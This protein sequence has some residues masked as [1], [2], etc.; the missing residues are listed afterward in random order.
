[1]LPIPS[2]EQQLICD[3]L[4]SGKNV[5]VNAVAGAGK[6]TT[7][8]L[9]M[10]TDSER[11][12]LLLTYNMELKNTTRDATLE[13]EIFNLEVHS[14]NSFGVKYISD[15]CKTDSGFLTDYEVKSLPQYEKI[16]IDEIQDCTHMYYE[17]IIKILDTQHD[18]QLCVLG[19]YKQTIFAFKGA[20]SRYLTLADKIFKTNREWV[21]LDLE[22]SYRLTRP[23]ANVMNKSVL[24]ED[25]FKAVK[26]GPPV[27]MYIMHPNSVYTI[28]RKL[29]NEP[30][31]TPGD[32]FIL[33]YSTKST[34]K[35]MIALENGL[36]N[37]PRIVLN[38]DSGRIDG[39][40]IAGKLV[41]SSFHRVKGLG[42]SKVIVMGFDAGYHFS[43]RAAVKDLCS[44]PMYVGLTRATNELIL[45]HAIY[46]ESFAWLRPCEDLEIIG[47]KAPKLFN[48]NKND[49]TI[50]VRE[51]IKFIDPK[52]EKEMRKLITCETI[53][54]PEI[55]YDIPH[56]VDG[57]KLDNGFTL[58][59]EVAEIT[60]IAIPSYV[61][62]KLH[63]TMQIYADLLADDY[64]FGPI[65]KYT[66]ANNLL[67]LSVYYWTMRNKYTY[68]KEQLLAHDWISQETLDLIADRL[69]NLLGDDDVVFERF[70][71]ASLDEFGLSS[72]LHG[73][74][75]CI[76]NDSIYEIKCTNDLSFD[77]QLQVLM[78]AWLFNRENIR[79][80]VPGMT[81]KLINA[82]SG[83]VQE[84]KCSDFP[85]LMGLLTK[86]KI[87]I[88]E[89]G[90]DDETFI[91]THL[92]NP[93]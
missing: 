80:G 72:Q 41:I 82:L 76:T 71:F 70:G 79:N 47:V 4:A 45:I 88:D 5:I 7:V 64:M 62:Y 48:S 31:V 91:K 30:G 60:G 9:S 89:A 22:T 16:Y 12:S 25:K 92:N 56:T 33:N 49:H 78:Y 39:K 86:N 36:E 46:N 53:V 68:R 37:I 35:R 10:L 55:V 77:H 14:Y 84:I 81:Y 13:H 43:D 32:I 61:Q 18:V 59:E 28:V 75:D 15:D 50:G 29:L 8:L 74:A 6:T 87:R 1:M 66:T 69:V 27:K 21:H 11:P 20:D 57:R 34:T 85:K 54:E 51:F 40:V 63:K 52:Y 44:N 24:H 90:I 38:D 93:E 2:D 58:T 17:L 42:R 19:D 73:F 3:A 65:E 26:D 83:E 67:R 23:M